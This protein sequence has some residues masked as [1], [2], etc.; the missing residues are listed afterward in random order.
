MDYIH[1]TCTRL[2]ALYLGCHRRALVESDRGEVTP[3]D[4]V[5]RTDGDCLSRR[6][7]R[8]GCERTVLDKSTPAYIGTIME[9]G[10]KGGRDEEKERGKGGREG[11]REGGKERERRG[12][13]GERGREITWEHG[14]IR[15]R[16]E[17]FK[18]QLIACSW[19]LTIRNYQ[20]LEGHAHE[21]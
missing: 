13:E 16:M 6:G 11:G 2:L 7:S 4:A 14:E 1:C 17:Y 9:E 20:L 19:L 5:D 8:G 10:K 18:R 21:R 3:S 15:G 12:R